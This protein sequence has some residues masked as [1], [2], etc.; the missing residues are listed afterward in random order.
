MMNKNVARASKTSVLKTI[1]TLASNGLDP[2]PVHGV[3][4]ELRRLQ[5]YW[6]LHGDTE[7]AE[8]AADCVSQLSMLRTLQVF[9]R[10]LERRGASRSDIRTVQARVE[11]LGSKLARKRTLSRI[12]RALKD[13]SVPVLELPSLAARLAEA[14]PG[15]AEA[16][17]ALI[18]K[19]SQ[20]K[21]KTLHE[22]R[23][24]IK[25]I[26]YQEEWLLDHP[27]GNK[28][29]VAA[30]KEAQDI[31]GTYEERAEF[32]K[33]AKKLDLRFSKRIRKDWRRARKRARALPQK[34][35]RHLPALAQPPGR[36]L[37]FRTK[38]GGAST[39]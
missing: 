4:I 37:P 21:R 7:N 25:T 15:H 39:P 16:L 8:V 32:R 17:H 36:I 3:R 20:P 34:L 29:L 35:R 9:E 6:E 26:R 11:K 13:L 18:R 1:Q 31:L 19:A 14:R 2:E 38:D 28:E 12:E 27:D 33:L 10:Y 30:L 22:L 23:L 24:K 5:A